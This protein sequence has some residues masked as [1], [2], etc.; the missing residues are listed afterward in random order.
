MGLAAERRFTNDHR[1]LN[2]ATGSGRQAS[3]L[4]VGLLITGLRPPGAP[5][6]LGADETV[7]RR[8]GRKIAAKGGDR[9]AVRSTQKQVIHCLGLK[10]VSMML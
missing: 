8:S 3:R 1:V 9:D 4:L 6:I 10:W 2:R 5:M 7:E